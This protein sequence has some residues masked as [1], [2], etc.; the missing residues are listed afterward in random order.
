MQVGDPAD[1]AHQL[2]GPVALRVERD[3]VPGRLEGHGGPGRILEDHHAEQ[4]RELP[5]RPVLEPQ[6]LGI[7]GHVGRDQ[8]HPVRGRR[9]R[10]PRIGPLPGL[11]EVGLGVA[12]EPDH[13]QDEGAIPQPPRRGRIAR[14][15]PLGIEQR[16]GL[17]GLVRRVPVELAQH[18]ELRIS[19]GQGPQS[20]RGFA[21]CPDRLVQ[22]ADG[23]QVLDEPELS[24]PV[25]DLRRR[26]APSRNG[27]GFPLRPIAFRAAG[28]SLR[29]RLSARTVSFGR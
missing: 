4:G 24:Q 15:Q 5:V 13:R 29:D 1:L 10:R 11:V 17:E 27:L 12:G 7:A 25:I 20:R 3:D 2:V 14:R 19:P 28:N 22:V 16:P 6:P 26:G 18:A 9:A 21:V 23:R 8:P